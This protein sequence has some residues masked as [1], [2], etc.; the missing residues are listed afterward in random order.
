M[1]THKSYTVQERYFDPTFWENGNIT[2]FFGNGCL[3]YPL[4]SHTLILF[5]LYTQKP[6]HILILA[7]IH[8]RSQTPTLL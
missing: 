5:L 1:E 6:T 8:I 2:T 4:P 3:K 7:I